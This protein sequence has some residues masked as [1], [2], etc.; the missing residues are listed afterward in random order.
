LVTLLGPGGVGK[1][2]LA[3]VVAEDAVALLPSGGAFVD[4][5]PVRDGFVARAVATALGVT[6]GSHQPLAEAVAA[7]LGTRRS[8]L[9]LDNCE[10]VIDEAAEFAER[11]LAACPATRVLVTSR[12]GIDD[13]LL[14]HAHHGQ[15]PGPAAR[16]HRTVPRRDR[17][18]RADVG[19][20]GSGPGGRHR[21]G[22]WRRCAQ[23]CWPAQCSR[24]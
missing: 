1:T 12:A 17:I 2:P 3:A 16:A 5:V 10:H 23:P 8:L 6:E 14:R 21:S 15:P 13:D 9:V 19:T 24:S 20:S 22:C 18:C 4:L 7:R 11:I